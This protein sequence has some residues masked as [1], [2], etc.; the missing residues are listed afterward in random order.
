MRCFFMDY[1]PIK[2]QIFHL[3]LHPTHACAFGI[4]GLQLY[5]NII[6]IVI[7]VLHN[8]VNYIFLFL[9]L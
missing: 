6:I 2:N 8:R 7:L 1:I 4:F 9:E 5:I 3:F